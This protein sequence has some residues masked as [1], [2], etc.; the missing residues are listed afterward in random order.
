MVQAVVRSSIARGKNIPP[1]ATRGRSVW[2]SA[3]HLSSLPLMA[4]TSRSS[5]LFSSRKRKSN[6][7][8]ESRSFS[9]ICRSLCLSSIGLSIDVHRP[10]QFSS[11]SSWQPLFCVYPSGPPIFSTI[12]FV[13]YPLS[14][15]PY[16]R[17]LVIFLTMCS[18]GTIVHLL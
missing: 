2:I 9:R 3:D 4:T 7:C 10:I 13:S 18:P 8:F 15:E 14:Q 17:R 5:S 12:L 6:S 16:K 11:R 1:A